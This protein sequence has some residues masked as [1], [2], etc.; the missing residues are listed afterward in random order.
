MDETGISEQ[1]GIA[2]TIC[3]ITESIAGTVLQFFGSNNWQRYDNA[4]TQPERT[5]IK[6]SPMTK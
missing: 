4:E 3:E 6:L 2:R 1:E 5:Q